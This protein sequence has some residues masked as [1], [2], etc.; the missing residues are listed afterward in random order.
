MLNSLSYSNPRTSTA[1]NP[2]MGTIAHL[3]VRMGLTIQSIPETERWHEGPYCH[4]YIAVCENINHYR[5]AIPAFV[6]QI[7]GSGIGIKD[8]S[9]HS[10]D[11]GDGVS[12][13]STPMGSAKKTSGKPTANEKALERARGWLPVR[14]LLFC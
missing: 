14:R 12:T 1:S 5:P 7:E 4:F 9:T 3:P 11:N 10:S 8:D 6:N 13:P 2:A